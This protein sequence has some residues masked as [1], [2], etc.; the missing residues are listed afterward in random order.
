MQIYKIVNK[1]NRK[2][3]IGKDSTDRSYYYGSGKILRHALKKYGKDNFEKI[4]LEQLPDNS[5]LKDLCDRETHWIKITN[6]VN[7]IMSYN[8]GGGGEGGDLSKYINYSKRGYSGDKFAAAQ[9]WYQSL[10]I[11]EQK[12]LHK[13]QAAKRSKVWYVSRIETPD[14][15]IKVINLREWERRTIPDYSVSCT[16]RIGGPNYGKSIKGWRCRSENDLNY[17]PYVNLRK[18]GHANIACKGK[19]WKLIDGKRVWSDK[20]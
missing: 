17:P 1:I 12:E 5:T 13:K 8:L 18:I 11:E 2:W 4:I 10:T 15:E 9:K 6:A 3:Y 19:S 16:A 7:D 20:R 14:I